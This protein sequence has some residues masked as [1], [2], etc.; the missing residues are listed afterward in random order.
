MQA[1]EAERDQWEAKYE[2][3]HKKYTEQEDRINKLTEELESLA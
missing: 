2:E 3:M 1:L